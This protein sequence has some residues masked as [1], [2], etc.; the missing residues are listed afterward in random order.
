MP[1]K[2]HILSYLDSRVSYLSPLLLDKFELRRQLVDGVIFWRR[3]E[4]ERHRVGRLR[5]LDG[6]AGL[7]ADQRWNLAIGKA[8]YVLLQLFV[9]LTKLWKYQTTIIVLSKVSIKC[10]SAS[11]R[12]KKKFPSPSYLLAG[13]IRL[14]R[15]KARRVVG[16]RFKPLGT[17]A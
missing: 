15:C 16:F 12:V 14:D 1:L 4:L 2:S 3:H 7:A 17:Q 5:R 9:F 6:L 10:E 13:T 11:Q 8:G